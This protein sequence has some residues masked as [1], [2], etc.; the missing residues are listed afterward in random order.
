MLESKKKKEKNL[1]DRWVKKVFNKNIIKSFK[2]VA[3]N[4]EI[5]IVRV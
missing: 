2:S 3:F 1:N 4:R 5:V